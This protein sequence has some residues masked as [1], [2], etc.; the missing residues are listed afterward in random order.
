MT[1][2][3]LDLTAF[4]PPSLY[5]LFAILSLIAPSVKS[6]WSLAYLGTSSALLLALPRCF[7]G[8]EEGDLLGSVMITLIALL[9]WVIVSY[10]RTYLEGERCQRRYIAALLSTLASVT[11]IALSDNLLT[12]GIAWTATSFCLHLLLT[13]YPERSGALLAAH[14]KFIA[15]RIADLAY[16][17]AL[18][19]IVTEG[20]TLQISGLMASVQDA[21]SLSPNLHLAAVLIVGAVILRSAQIPVHGW[22]MQVMEAPTPV[23]ALLHAGV[24][25]IG[26]FVLLRL[27]PL[28]SQAPLAQALLVIVGSSSAVLAGIVM[29]TRISIKVRLAWST[30]AQLGFMLMECGLG[31]YSLAFLHLLSHSCYKAYLFL[32]AG[33][34]VIETR[35]RRLYS[36]FHTAARGRSIAVAE[37]MALTTVLFLIC[38]FLVPSL[39]LPLPIF[40]IVGLAVTPFMWDRGISILS[41]SLRT[42]SVVGLYIVGHLLLE[43][44][45]SAHD[46][47]SLVLTL[48][49]ITFFTM[50]YG[51]QEQI[52]TRPDGSFSRTLYRWAFSGFYLD[53]WFTKTTFKLWPVQL[54][55]RRERS[56]RVKTRE[57]FAG[58]EL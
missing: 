15:S 42:V 48:L 40:I 41:R 14:K 13:L 4:S 19:L 33:D 36:S 46:G 17:L 44:L 26:G 29:M 8:G 53:E 3:I 16:L 52:I 18:A 32:S 58:K 35:R 55:P 47:T 12:I 1:T 34:A 49:V 39:H 11:V 5:L 31:L 23:S 45:F 28:L 30:C 27:S 51:I 9:G 56:M 21:G 22:L 2:S 37:A 7:V 10:S 25:N 54:V 20:E 43:P 38:E 6:S 50:L 57:A 24:I